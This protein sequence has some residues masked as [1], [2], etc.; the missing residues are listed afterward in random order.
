MDSHPRYY[1]S[2]SKRFF[3]SSTMTELQQLVDKKLFALVEAWKQQLEQ[4]K[5]LLI[6]SAVVH[7][8]FESALGAMLCKL[9]SEYKKLNK[10]DKAL[11]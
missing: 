10:I 5:V 1:I 11:Y 3:G 6:P 4:L 9:V 2:L 8:Y 7:M